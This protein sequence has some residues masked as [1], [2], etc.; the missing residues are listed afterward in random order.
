M[1]GAIVAGGA[2]SRF[3]GEPKGL[4]SVGGRRIVDRVA[5]ALRGASSELILISSVTGASDWLPGVRVVPDGWRQRGSLVGIH[6]ALTHARQPI[7]LVAWDMPF[8][9]GPLLRLLCDRATR[10][11]FAA[12]PSSDSGLEPFCAV[13]TP[14]CLPWI[15][16][17]MAADDLRLSRVL[18]RLPEFE[19]IS[20]TDVSSV[21]DPARLFFNVNDT[22]D[23]AEAERLA[24]RV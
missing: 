8:V 10:S 12:V 18:E 6:A 16:A 17:A 2:S 1:I 19:Q 11:S 7:L 24:L 23:L 22:D 14:K 4:H 13:Y 9:T 21:G 5:D 3:G 20:V 15:E